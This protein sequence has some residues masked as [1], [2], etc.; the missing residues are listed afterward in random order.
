MSLMCVDIWF[1][2]MRQEI[3]VSNVCGDNGPRAR[4]LEYMGVIEIIDT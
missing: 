2:S 4:S 3:D 1:E